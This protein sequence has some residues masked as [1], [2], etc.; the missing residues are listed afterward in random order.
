VERKHGGKEREGGSQLVSL[1]LKW[2]KDLDRKVQTYPDLNT[3]TMI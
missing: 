2:R 3:M 1:V